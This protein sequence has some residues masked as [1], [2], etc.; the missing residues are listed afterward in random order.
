MNFP[1]LENE[2]SRSGKSWK[3]IMIM[4]SHGILLIDRGIF[5]TEG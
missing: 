5:L 4:G 2:F 3:M 1:G